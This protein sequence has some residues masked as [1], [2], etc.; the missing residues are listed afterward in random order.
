ME[1]HLAAGP[2]GAGPVGAQLAAQL[3]PGMIWGLHSGIGMMT[4]AMVHF[5]LAPAIRQQRKIVLAAA[6]RAHP[7]QLRPPTPFPLA[8]AHQGLDQ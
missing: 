8:S 2:V 5:G 6:Y 7:E 4:P 1:R 3:V